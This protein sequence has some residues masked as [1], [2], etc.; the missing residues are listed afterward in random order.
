MQSM[1]FQGVGHDLESEQHK[2]PITEVL[3]SET[4]VCLRVG[5]M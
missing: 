1:G 5:A 4:K 3:K 2:I